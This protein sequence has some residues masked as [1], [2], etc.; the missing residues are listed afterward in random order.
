M[1]TIQV[2]KPFT[3]Q[4]DPQH[5]QMP[6]P[7]DSSKTIT[8]TQPSEMRYYDVGLYDVDAATAEHWYVKAHLKGYEEPPKALGSAEFAMAQ[9]QKPIEQPPVEG[10]EAEGAKEAPAE[11]SQPMPPDARPPRPAPIPPNVRRAEPKT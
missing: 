4:L 7:N 2:V 1:P 9:I 6:D 10:T 5:T 11:P 8:V 3:L